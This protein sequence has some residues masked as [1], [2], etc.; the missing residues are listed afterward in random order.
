M[1]LRKGSQ[2]YIQLEMFNLTAENFEYKSHSSG[3]FTHFATA[4]THVTYTN[5]LRKLKQFSPIN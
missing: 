1:L 5:V 2:R 3:S 4:Y